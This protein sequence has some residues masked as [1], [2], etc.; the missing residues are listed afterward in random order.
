M[1]QVSNQNHLPDDI[2]ARLKFPFARKVTNMSRKFL[3]L[4]LV[5]QVANI[6]VPAQRGEAAS[7]KQNQQPVPA[8]DRIRALGL[9]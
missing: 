3:I 9:V 4:I 1:K 5:L 8:C 7:G 2:G 6:S